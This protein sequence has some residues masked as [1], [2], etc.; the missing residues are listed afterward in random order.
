MALLGNAPD[1]AF[2]G[3]NL[4]CADDAGSWGA[5]SNLRA[6]QIAACCGKPLDV[7]LLC[8]VHPCT[9]PSLLRTHSSPDLACTHQLTASCKLMPLL[10]QVKGDA[11]LARV[12]D[13]AAAHAGQG[14]RLPGQGV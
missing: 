1:N 9:A 2:E 11:F 7:S 12:F 13:D 10:T 5:P 14:R 8:D 3:I 4:Y 6:S